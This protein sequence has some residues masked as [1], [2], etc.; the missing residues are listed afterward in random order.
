MKDFL[1]LQD[2]NSRLWVEVIIFL[3]AVATVDVLTAASNDF[4]RAENE[5][6][7]ISYKTIM[8]DYGLK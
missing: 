2:D 6:P 1:Y 3:D 8:A 5:G 4:L 7:F